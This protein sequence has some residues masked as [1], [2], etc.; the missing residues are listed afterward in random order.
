MPLEFIS[1]QI[2]GDPFNGGPLTAGISETVIVLDDDAFLQ[3]DASDT[4]DQF[5]IGGTNF[6]S[7]A[8]PGNQGTGVEIYTATVAGQTVTFGYLTS[9]GDGVDD[10]IDRL[11]VLSGTINPSSIELII[12]SETI[13]VLF[14]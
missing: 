5:S 1:L 10:A 6:T 13:I 9:A 2:N 14:K 8:W 3:P 4:G 7:S 12:F 11:V